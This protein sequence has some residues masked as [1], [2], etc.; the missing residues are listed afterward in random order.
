VAGVLHSSARATARVR[1]EL[2]APK[3]TTSVHNLAI[4]AEPDHGHRMAGADVDIGCSHRPRDPR[5]TVL[6]LAEEGMV[7]LLPVSWTPRLGVS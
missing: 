7:G 1:T 4:R 2:Q 5:S 6:T 3:R